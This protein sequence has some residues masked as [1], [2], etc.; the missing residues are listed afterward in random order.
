M[1]RGQ[2][3]EP[4]ACTLF[5][6]VASAE[7]H[8]L[9]KLARSVKWNVRARDVRSVRSRPL[10]TS[11][12]RGA[13]PAGVVVWY[14]IS[15]MRKYTFVFI[16]LVF[17]LG[18]CLSGETARAQQKQVPPCGQPPEFVSARPL[19]KHEQEKV[20]KVKPQGSVA[21]VV[22]SGG[23]VIDAKVV[24]SASDEAGKLMVDLAKGMTFKPR[25][26]CGPIKTVV[27]FNQGK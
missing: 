15:P 26:S 16:S 22:N 1:Q 4:E 6:P 9:S 10:A 5:L 20:K 17:G 27:N 8:R 14:Y 18:A 25:P 24:Q 12:G 13:G 19:P 11:N 3:S 23:E 21:I 2:P 7:K